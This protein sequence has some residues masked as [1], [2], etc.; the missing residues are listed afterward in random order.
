[1]RITSTLIVSLALVILGIVGLTVSLQ[2]PFHTPVTAI[3]G[4]GVFPTAFLVI[5][6]FFS[7]ILV[8][9]ELVKSFSNSESTESKS[10]IIAKK[11]AIRILLM[12]AA[13]TTY[14]LV[15]RYAG[16][17]FA[18][19]VLTLVLLWLFGYRNKIVS[20]ILA[21][22]FTLLMHSIFQTFLRISLP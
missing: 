16:F 14:T 18:T 19:P 10:P 3:G 17:I 11:D 2:L 21:I 8:I 15:L 5:I 13:V 7:A 4:P 20:P 6:T 12:I 1:M 22:G 9:T